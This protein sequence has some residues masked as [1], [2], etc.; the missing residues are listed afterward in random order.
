MKHTTRFLMLLAAA[1]IAT[2][3]DKKQTTSQQ[4]DG[5]Q[6]K[7]AEVAQNIKDYT[8]S[9][10]EEFVRSE[11]KLLTELN[12]DLD[13]LAAK[14]DKASAEVKAEAQPR[15]ETLRGQTARLNKQLD[16]A[17]SATESSWEKFKVE[18]RKTHTESKVEFD[19]ARQWLSDKVA[20]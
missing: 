7:A 9:E 2:G 15:I 16:D 10:K 13:E 6:T 8:F 11:R 4:L 18:V 17:A 1:V 19:K 3:C 12:R 14:V 20:P 5:V